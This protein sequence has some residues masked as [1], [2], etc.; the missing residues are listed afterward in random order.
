MPLLDSKNH[1]IDCGVATTET[2]DRQFSKKTVSNRAIDI[3]AFEVDKANGTQDISSS[4]TIG[5]A[6][7]NKNTFSQTVT[8]CSISIIP[9]KQNFERVVSVESSNTAILANPQSNDPL[10]LAYQSDG[11]VSIN[12]TLDNNEKVATSF[13]TKTK[14]PSPVYTFNNHL[15]GSLAKH[16]VNQS[17][18]VANNTTSPPNHYPIY[19]TFNQQSNSYVKNSGFYANSFDFSGITVNKTGSGGITSVTAITPRHAIG[20]AHYP[21]SVNDVMYFCDSNNQTVS[22]TIVD[23]IFLNN[24]DSVIVKFNQDLPNTV[25]KY[26]FI[27]ADWIDYLPLDYPSITTPN[28]PTGTTLNYSGFGAPMVITSHYRWDENWPFQRN[29]RYAYIVPSYVS[30][31]INNNQ[32]GVPNIS[33]F[34]TGTIWGPNINK[35]TNYNGIESGIQAGDSGLPCFYIINNDL[36]FVMK[37]LGPASGPFMAEYLTDVQNSINS[38]GAEGYSIQ[39]VDLSGFT[40]FSS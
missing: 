14:T 1:P 13:Q 6:V 21:P 30:Y 20:A 32:R 31:Y 16:I 38:I 23:R 2:F 27:P 28:L 25:K 5:D 39:T 10:Y 35:F 19:S 11:I 37:H 9:V 34:A 36:V 7:F 40:D 26:K 33:G 15:S 18:L 24:S 17:E 3:V 22:R 12:V 8:D 4:E 29:N